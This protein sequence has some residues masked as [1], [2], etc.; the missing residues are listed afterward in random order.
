MIHLIPLDKPSGAVV[1]DLGASLKPLFEVPILEHE[2][3][4]LPASGYDPEREQYSSSQ[5][6]KNLTAFKNTLTNVERVLGIVSVDLYA[7]ELDFIF[8]EADSHE[9][10]GVISI[11]RLQQKFY[12]LPPDVAL[13]Q[14]RI[15]KEAAHGLGHIYNLGHCDNPA[16]VMYFSSQ[17]DEIDQ[18]GN[19]FCQA[20]HPGRSAV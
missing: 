20:C 18:K 15:L 16:C 6:L 8:G 4:S 12:H 7:D 13:F 11:V 9:R 3:T 2:P 5:M 10:V 17:I 19:T 14:Q 1:G